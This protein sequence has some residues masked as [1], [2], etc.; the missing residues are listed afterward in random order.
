MGGTGKNSGIWEGGGVQGFSRMVWG[1]RVVVVVATMVDVLI[2]LLGK[3][4]ENLS[5]FSFLFRVDF[6]SILEW[7]G[8]LEEVAALN[9]PL[10]RFLD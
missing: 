8:L 4:E 2:L 10:V 1:F 9:E 7:V 3:K 6:C 5:I